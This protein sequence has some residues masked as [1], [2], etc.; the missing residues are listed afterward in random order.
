MPSGVIDVIL[1]RYLEEIVY[2][3]FQLAFDKAFKLDTYI[4]GKEATYYFWIYNLKLDILIRKM[5]FMFV[6]LA[7]QYVPFF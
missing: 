5:G 3:F 6:T 7:S 1:P 4:L 2:R